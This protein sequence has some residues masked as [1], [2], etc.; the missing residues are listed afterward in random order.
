MLKKILRFLPVSI[1]GITFLLA[2]ILINL[3]NARLKQVL[4]FPLDNGNG[5]NAELRMIKKYKTKEVRIA[6]TVKEMLLGPAILELDR[7][8][9]L[10]TKLQSLILND[11]TLFLDFSKDFF[12]MDSG[13]SFPFSDRIDLIK[14][15]LK[16]NYPFLKEVV[17]TINGQLPGSPY[18]SLD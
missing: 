4:L 18:Y 1:I 12:Q 5:V 15:N 17:I 9:P 6:H 8:V 11:Q 3:E 13:L 16:F 7:I 2:V 10:G 14:R